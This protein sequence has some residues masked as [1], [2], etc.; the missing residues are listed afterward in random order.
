M[1]KLLRLALWAMV[2]GGVALA[3]DWLPDALAELEFFRAREY[4][5]AGA[6][7]LDK[8]EVLAE[9]AIAPF[10]SVFDDLPSIEQ[11]LEQ[12]PLEQSLPIP[13]RWQ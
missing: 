13:R 11:R 8:E 6:R 9:A 2:A 3:A 10:V 5:V 7:L 4:R 1:R 12:H